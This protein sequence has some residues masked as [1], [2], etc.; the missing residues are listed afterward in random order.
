MTGDDD[1]RPSLGQGQRRVVSAVPIDEQDEDGPLLTLLAILGVAT[2]QQ[3]I[4]HAFSGAG[5]VD[6]W[7]A[8]AE[9]RG[10]I[11]QVGSEGWALRDPGRLRLED[12]R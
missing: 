11:A 9:R 7:L 5:V 2:R 1:R 12:L 6:L 8:G 3:F 10:L 4:D